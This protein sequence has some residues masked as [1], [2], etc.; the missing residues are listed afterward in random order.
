[1]LRLDRERRADRGGEADGLVPPDVAA[2][3]HVDV[4]LGAPHDE[5]RLHARAAAERLVDGGLERQHL[6]A[7]VAAVGRDDDLGRG[8]DDPVGEGVG[9]E[10]PEDDGV[11]RAD[12]RAGEH[13]DDRLRDERHV[14]GD[15]IALHDPMVP[16]CVREAAHVA[17]EVGVGDHAAVAGLPLPEQRDL[18]AEAALHLAVQGVVREVGGAAVEPARVRLLPLQHGVPGLEPM[19]FRRD[20]GPEGVGFVERTAVRALVGLERVD[21][22]LRREGGGGPEAAVFVQ[23]RR[24]VLAGGVVGHRVLRGG[25]GGAVAARAV[26][27]AEAV[28]VV[29]VA[30]V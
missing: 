3:L 7:A 10:A 1:V 22:G 11:H 23:D 5:D 9:R 28:A 12:P 8:V 6:A 13:G 29:R 15:A 24:Q 14:D 25:R 17:E 21:A 16:E 18:V 27:A 4:V 20:L 26:G 2:G 30:R 19:Q